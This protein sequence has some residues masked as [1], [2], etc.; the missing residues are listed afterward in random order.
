MIKLYRKNSFGIG[1]WTIQKVGDCMLVYSHAVTEG[2]S[3][4]Q[5]EDIVQRNNSGRTLEEQVELEMQ[6]RINRMLDKGYKRTREEAL[7]G[8]TNQMGM[9]SPMLAQS[10]NNIPNPNI[11][12]A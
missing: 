2:A 3:E 8:A 7:Q 12:N 11:R 9:L 5:H 10:L 4:V 1:T 6:S